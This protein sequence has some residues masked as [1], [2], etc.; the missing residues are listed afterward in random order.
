MEHYYLI[1]QSKIVSNHT[2]SCSTRCASAW[3][4]LFPFFRLCL[5]DHL[6]HFI[7]SLMSSITS[8]FEWSSRFVKSH[9]YG[10]Q[11]SSSTISDTPISFAKIRAL[12]SSCCHSL[13]CFFIFHIGV[14]FTKSYNHLAF[15]VS[16]NHPSASFVFIYE[17]GPSK[18]A[19]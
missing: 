17:D 14:P 8:P 11:F 18:L 6:K 3:A 1:K 15:T 12:L 19:L 9:C 5:Y 4:T 16:N 10:F 13:H 2:D 7:S